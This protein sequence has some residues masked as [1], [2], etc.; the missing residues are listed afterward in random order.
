MPAK[1]TY[2]RLTKICELSVFAAEKNGAVPDE[3]AEGSAGH[4]IGPGYFVEGWFLE[5]LAVGQPLSLLRVRRNETAK[6]G[7]FTS[8]PVT[9]LTESEIRTENSVYCIEYYREEAEPRRQAVFQETIAIRPP[10]PAGS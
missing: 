2:V 7:V 3:P 9:H 1:P 8:S 10:S 5:K 4:H 6:L